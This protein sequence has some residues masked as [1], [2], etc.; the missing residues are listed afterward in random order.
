MVFRHN[1][2]HKPAAR[3]MDKQTVGG[4]VLPRPATVLGP[5]IPAANVRCRRVKFVLPW[6][7]LMRRLPRPSG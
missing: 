7:V 3:E 5:R 1:A 2:P 6:R 4:G